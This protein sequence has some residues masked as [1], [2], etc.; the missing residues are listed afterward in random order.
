MT[1]REYVCGHT[2]YFSA[3]FRQLPASVTMCK[4]VVIVAGPRPDEFWTRH[5]KWREILDGIHA[6]KM[7]GIEIVY[8]FPFNF[9][10]PF[11]PRIL[12]EVERNREEVKPF[13]SLFSKCFRVA[14]W[15]TF[16]C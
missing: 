1:R 10:A 8:L 9:P 13:A 5:I 7:R 3:I 11:P 15:V 6:K 16:S 12:E 14:Y 4:I 2:P